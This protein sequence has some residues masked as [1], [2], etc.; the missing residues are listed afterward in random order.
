[1]LKPQ[2]CSPCRKTKDDGNDGEAKAWTVAAQWGSQPQQGA[3][4]QPTHEP[5][6]IERI[7]FKA[8]S[9]RLHHM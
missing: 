5:N 6:R 1:M 8:R 4:E 3:A 9:I 7:S 2:R